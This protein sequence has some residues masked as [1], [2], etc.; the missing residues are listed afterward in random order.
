MKTKDKRHRVGLM[1]IFLFVLL[2]LSIGIDVV[3]LKRVKFVSG[4]G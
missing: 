2:L 4:A 1:G 3:S